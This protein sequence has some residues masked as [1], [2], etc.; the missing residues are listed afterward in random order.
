MKRL[1][2]RG[3]TII[4]VLIVLAVLSFAFAIAMATANK[5]AND[6]RNAEE[7]SRALGIEKSQ[8]EYL[9]L[10]TSKKIELPDDEV[11]CLN[12]DGTPVKGFPA[13]YDD[14]TPLPEGINTFTNFPDECVLEDQYITSV[15]TDG[16]GNY[17][18]RV[19][20]AGVSGSGGNSTSRQ[21]LMTYR[22]HELTT[23]ADFGVKLGS[24]P[25]EA[26]IIVAAVPL[27]DGDIRVDRTPS[28]ANAATANKGGSGVTLTNQTGVTSVT[29]TTSNAS[30]SIVF[31]GTSDYSFYTA[32]LNSVPSA[33][34]GSWKACKGNTEIALPS[35]SAAKQALPNQSTNFTEFKIYPQC[36][37]INVKDPDV[38]VYGDWY[39]DAYYHTGHKVPVYGAKYWKAGNRRGDLDI[40]ANS[41][42]NGQF[43]NYPLP[44]AIGKEVGSPHTHAAVP[45][46]SGV[47]YFSG[48]VASGHHNGKGYYAVN[49]AYEAQ[50]W[51]RDDPH[52]DHI[53]GYSDWKRDII[54][55]DPASHDEYPCPT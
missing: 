38:A 10:A 36:G 35:T 52:E 50:D 49:E 42:Y 51:I 45:N 1:N 5:G 34:T 28:C 25:G 40:Y 53:T 2:N 43:Q 21:E 14:G 44:G 32:T 47:H 4:E 27:K 8:M 30:S 24:A 54:R 41:G 29:G 48:Y 19:R 46:A 9:R 26:K 13:G 20:W 18:V 15:T 16:D 6:A 23:D 12:P 55:W 37:K 39:R 33:T 17:T 31:P 11:F 7:Q 3:D 22:T